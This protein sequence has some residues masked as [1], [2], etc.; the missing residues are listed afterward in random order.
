V[1]RAG[2]YAG[3]SNRFV[4]WTNRETC[5]LF[6][7]PLEQILLGASEEG[8]CSP[9]TPHEQFNDAFLASMAAAASPAICRNA[10]RKAGNQDAQARVYRVATRLLP[11]VVSDTLKPPS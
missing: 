11:E 4:D 9:R 6:M 3:T 7:T 5:V 2:D 1:K 8:A 10:R